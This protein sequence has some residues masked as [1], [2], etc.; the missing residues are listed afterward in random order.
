MKEAKG[1]GSKRFPE[2]CFKWEDFID[3]ENNAHVYRIFKK[4]TIEDVLSP[5]I[6]SNIKG[7]HRNAEQKINLVKKDVIKAYMKLIIYDMIMHGKV[8]KLPGNYGWITLIVKDK[9]RKNGRK[10]GIFYIIQSENL[11]KKSKNPTSNFTHVHIKDIQLLRQ[12]TAM[13]NHFPEK[14]HTISSFNDYVYNELEITK[15][16]MLI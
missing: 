5:L 12:V 7:V 1:R 13:V 4:D 6:G 8:I 3:F 14:Y 10:I 9:P 15:N 11:N 2:Y 16:L